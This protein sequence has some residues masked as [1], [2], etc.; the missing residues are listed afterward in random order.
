MFSFQNELSKRELE[1]QKVVSTLNKREAEL[2]AISERELRLKKEVQE[3]SKSKHQLRY[4][5]EDFIFLL[6]T[7]KKDEVIGSTVL[8]IIN[9]TLVLN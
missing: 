4:K 8:F 1:A 6:H 7:S 3:Q 5:A 9:T 2:K